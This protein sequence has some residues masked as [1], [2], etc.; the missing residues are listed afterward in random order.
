MAAVSPPHPPNDPDL[1]IKVKK[2]L[3]RVSENIHISANE[4]SL[5]VYR[6]QEHV[7]RAL[8]PTVTRRQHVTAL[9]SQLQGACYD[10]EYALGAVRVM[11]DAGDKFIS[12]QELLKSAIFHRQ[13]LK[14]EQTRRC[15]SL[16]STNS[17]YDSVW[18]CRVRVALWRLLPSLVFPG[19]R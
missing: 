6:L 8:P 13:Q 16:V 9:H 2:A 3:E 12:L 5:A 10:V 1:E 15:G 14:Y 4:P 17:T 11:K 18:D 7:R 19:W